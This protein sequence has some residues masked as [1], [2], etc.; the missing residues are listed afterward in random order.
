MCS[1]NEPGGTAPWETAA[2]GIPTVAYE[3][4]GTTSLSKGSNV[5]I[6]CKPNPEALAAKLRECVNLSNIEREAK[7]NH[8]KEVI[9]RMFNSHLYAAR[10]VLAY[11]A[12]YSRGRVTEHSSFNT[13]SVEEVMDYAIIGSK[14][15]EAEKTIECLRQTQ[16]FMS[17]HTPSEE[18]VE[19]RHKHLRSNKFSVRYG[20][21]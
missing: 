1:F 12:I 2:A 19:G 9:T 20:Q 3:H 21:S 16:L 6:T 11:M 5:L 17:F 18:E 8:A 4:L 10:H 7:G 14:R 15:Y 13:Y